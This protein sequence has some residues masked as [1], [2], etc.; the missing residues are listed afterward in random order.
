MNGTIDFF[1]PSGE[2]IAS[3]VGMTEAAPVDSGAIRLS[4]SA[5]DVT[6]VQ[7]DNNTLN[8]LLKDNQ[9]IVIKDF[10]GDTKKKLV[11]DD[12]K[13]IF[14]ADYLDKEQFNGLQFKPLQSID[15]VFE[16]AES[17]AT[18]SNDYIWVVPLIAAVALGGLA[19]AAASD[20]GSG[21]GNNSSDTEEEK[22]KE[23]KDNANQAIDELEHLSD[24]QKEEARQAVNDAT[25][26]AGAEQALADAEALNLEE[27]KADANEAIDE[28][29]YLSDE[30]KEEAH[31][32]VND[33]TDVP[34]VEKAQADAV[35]LNDQEEPS[36]LE[37]IIS[38][39]WNAIIAIPKG[40]LE[41]IKSII[42]MLSDYHFLLESAPA[43][44]T[45]VALVVWEALV[46]VIH[47]PLS[48]I[49][50]MVQWI[51]GFTTGILGGIWGP[52]GTI[53]QILNG[54]LILLDGLGNGLKIIIESIGIGVIS[55]PA[56][57]TGA[58]G[59]V[60]TLVKGIGALLSGDSSA[61]EDFISELSQTALQNPLIPLVLGD[62]FTALMAIPKLAVE[63]IC[64]VAEWILGIITG[65]MQF[66]P[67]LIPIASVVSDFTLAI[68]GV[69]I[70]IHYGLSNV[71][72]L[73]TKL[74]MALIMGLPIA[75]STGTSAVSIIEAFIKG[76]LGISSDDSSSDNPIINF[77]DSIIDFISSPISSI[78]NIISSISNNIQDFL[79]DP[80][81]FIWNMLQSAID[82]I[83]APC[84]FI[85]DTV[86]SI[87]DF[88]AAPF[89]AI[90]NVISSIIGD[91]IECVGNFI[92]D[93]FGTIGD[94]F[95]SI[96][97]IILAPCKAII[98]AI[99]SIFDFVTNPI[100][101]ILSLIGDPL[102]LMVKF[103]TDPAGT[104][105]EL[106]NNVIDTILSPFK[107]II[108][109]IS[110]VFYGITHPLETISNLINDIVAKI[111]GSSSDENTVSA[112][113]DE[114]A[115]SNDTADGNESN[116]YSSQLSEI[117]SSLDELAGLKDM[118]ESESSEETSTQ[119]LSEDLTNTAEESSEDAVTPAAN[120]ELSD[121]Q[122]DSL[123]EEN[124]N[125][126]IDLDSL[127]D[128]DNNPIAE[129]NN[130][131]EEQYSSDD[132][133]G[134]NAL[135]NVLAQQQLNEENNQL[136]AA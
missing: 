64:V 120:E 81:G 49:S 66:I 2:K 56:I 116:L 114:S 90:S 97:D 57:I 21:G 108:D 73:I 78:E 26:T 52:L 71:V 32:A 103:I 126:D 38:G 41:A 9:K 28:L 42:P 27:A 67:G 80:V 25:D 24:E 34:G 107:G 88:I 127:T 47:A 1:S 101:S 89:E 96:I 119:T 87:I 86:G 124:N 69:L 121:E 30:Q 46:E 22:L 39:I 20:N 65:V 43:A 7:K 99:S 16:G 51:T 8:I 55:L 106:F 122:I 125:S 35:S 84:K 98:D 117:K 118:T 134:Y 50:N 15:E 136:V 129:E 48:F 135:D 5:R 123:L 31:Q 18:E 63:I 19:I 85:I 70:A 44:L 113:L 131:P 75:I 130:T 110:E 74:G 4:V 104:I 68:D 93:P 6:G 91:I 112:S 37:N 36:F 133:G 115:S 128:A 111:F 76:A 109:F 59:W 60:I 72:N 105:T 23:A 17:S 54:I 82:V 102:T 62:L 53:P 92:S 100:E 12:G 40:L 29:E 45:G 14:E 10:F 61:M 13:E 132:T 94:V 3:T 11:F 58:I 77:I 33:A 83:L 79:S 95:Q